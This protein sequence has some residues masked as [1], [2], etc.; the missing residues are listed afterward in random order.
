MRHFR[1]SLR[2]VMA[3]LSEKSQPKHVVRHHQAI[4]NRRS[5]GRKRVWPAFLS[6]V[7]VAFALGIILIRIFSIKPDIDPGCAYD[8]YVHEV[9]LDAY[10]AVVDTTTYRYGLDYSD[11]VWDNEGNISDYFGLI[12]ITGWE[13]TEQ[14]EYWGTN[15]EGVLLESDEHAYRVDVEMQ[16]KTDIPYLN[17]SNP[18]DKALNV[19][20]FTYVPPYTLSTGNYRVGILVRDGKQYNVLWTENSIKVQ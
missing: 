6:A 11:Y 4:C 9:S 14:G 8:Q 10:P 20:F 1:R 19:A 2:I 16:K 3:N 12:L 5:S 13:V 17:Q 18:K 7:I 15:M